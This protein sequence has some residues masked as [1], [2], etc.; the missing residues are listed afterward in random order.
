MGKRDNE[1]VRALFEI[2]SRINRIIHRKI[3][4]AVD[5]KGRPGQMY[6]LGKLRKARASDQ[7]GMRVSDLATSFGI[8]ASGITQMVTTLE[9]QGLVVRSMDAEDRRAVRVHLTEA[10]IGMIESL[11]AFYGSIFAGLIDHLGEKR[12]EDLLS[13]LSD[14]AEYMDKLD[15]GAA[16]CGRASKEGKG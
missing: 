12:A 14:A 4:T 2:F 6:L 5:F 1:Q 10:G 15:Y 9:D 8:T 3:F 16:A 7:N 11:E 13:L